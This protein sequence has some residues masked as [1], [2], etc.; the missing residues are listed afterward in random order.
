MGTFIIATMTMMSIL[1]MLLYRED[2]R[3][4]KFEQQVARSEADI[5]S[6]PVK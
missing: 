2:N 1:L 6:T 3:R 4:K 5:Q